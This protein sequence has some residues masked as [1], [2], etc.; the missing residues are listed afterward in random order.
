MILLNGTE[1]K[2]TIFPDGTSQVWKIDESIFKKRLIFEQ[3]IEWEF[4]SEGEFMQV[5]QLCD[6]IA[7]KG[8]YVD[9]LYI[10]YFPYI[11]FSFIVFLQI[12]RYWSWH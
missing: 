10:P 11:P 1:I 4:E 12:R 9:M 3:H 8:G 2:P 6:L 5:A 7:A